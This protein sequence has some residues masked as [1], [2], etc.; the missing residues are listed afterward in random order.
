MWKTTSMSVF[1]NP[2]CLSFMVV[3]S[4][5]TVLKLE[6]VLF[7]KFF[8]K[9]CALKSGMRL[10]YGCGFYTDVYGI[11]SVKSRMKHDAFFF[12]S[13][14]SHDFSLTLYLIA[15]KALRRFSDKLQRAVWTCAPA[16]QEQLKVTRHL[17]R[18]LRDILIRNNFEIPLNIYFNLIYRCYL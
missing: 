3:C 6:T 7:F 8:S 9:F 17:L 1:R 18:H 10:I 13:K 16:S 14:L 5:A 11:C 2:D 15:A 4:N 12:L